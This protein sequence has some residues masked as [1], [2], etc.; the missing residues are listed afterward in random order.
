[1]PC[2]AS[3][4]IQRLFFLNNRCRALEFISSIV[5]DSVH[6]ARN[7][8]ESALVGKVD[9]SRA[10]ASGCQGS[11][12]EFELVNTAALGVTGPA[13]QMAPA[14]DRDKAPMPHGAPAA[15][16]DELDAEP[17][18]PF[19]AGGSVLREL[20][21]HDDSKDMETKE[22]LVKRLSSQATRMFCLLCLTTLLCMATVSHCHTMQHVAALLTQCNS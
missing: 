9:K 19:P 11:G 6:E 14:L 10:E 12:E 3:C 22:A 4:L 17:S 1:M 13:E 7:S 8:Y 18:E 16:G 2:Y 20:E 5:L 15:R 21:E